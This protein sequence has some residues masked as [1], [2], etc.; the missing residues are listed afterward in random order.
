M[1]LT[2]TL[3]PALDQS[4]F[5][6]RLALGDVNRI[7]RSTASPGGKGVNVSRAVH[8]LGGET[9]ATG[10]LAGESGDYIARA[11]EA[12][13]FPQKFV[14]VEG[15]TRRN[16]NL[17]DCTG[18]P[19]SLNELGPAISSQAWAEFL[20]YLSHAAR[21]ARWVAL[22]GSLPRGLNPDCYAQVVG[23]LR[24]SKA[25]VALDA[26]GEALG[27]GLER[28][29]DL[30]KPNAN[31]AGRLL[32]A[33]PR[34]LAEA[35]SSAREL[36]AKHPKTA[37]LLSMGGIGAVLAEAQGCWIGKSPKVS[38]RSTLGCGD[39][40][41]GGYLVAESR[42]AAPPDRLAMALAAGSALAEADTCRTIHADRVAELLQNTQVARAD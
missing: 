37:V 12:E 36:R 39:A 5:F 38:V 6:E 34:T 31:E 3:N 2:V 23:A 15:Q 11:I 29:P 19:T 4:M 1:I 32:G 28:A 22:C 9:L 14:R 30:V 7:V 16:F 25:H 35:L 8:A 26:D 10:F 18:V 24:S 42:G 17:N 33:E 40:F 27:L 20:A 13:G 21:A 41:L